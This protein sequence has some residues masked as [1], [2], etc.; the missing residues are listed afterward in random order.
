MTRLFNLVGLKLVHGCVSTGD[1]TLTATASTIGILKLETFDENNPATP[2]FFFEAFNLR[3]SDG[4]QALFAGIS[5][6]QNVMGR[7]IWQTASG[8]VL[9]LDFQV[10][11]NPFGGTNCTLAGTLIT[12]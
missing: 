4:P 1:Q 12:G 10:E 8:K 5:D 3:P 7:L 6:S 11:T 2:P 9:T